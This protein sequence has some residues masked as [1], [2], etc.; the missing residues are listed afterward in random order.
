MK[1]LARKLNGATEEAYYCWSNG[2]KFLLGYKYTSMSTIFRQ[3]KVNY[4]TSKNYPTKVM[5]IIVPNDFSFWS[6]DNEDS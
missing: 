6:E 3:G 4:S 2:G 5:H 1:H